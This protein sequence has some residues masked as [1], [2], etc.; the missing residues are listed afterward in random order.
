MEHQSR[1]NDLL[2]EIVEMIPNENQ[3]L[4]N[5]LSALQDSISEDQK[6]LDSLY[7]QLS[8][9]ESA[10]EKLTSP[11]NRTGVFLQLLEVGIALISVGDSEFIAS[12][13]PKI[14]SEEL[15]CGSR[16]KVNDTYSVVGVMPP[17]SG[18]QVMRVAEVLTNNRVRIGDSGPGNTSGRVVL[19]SA[20]LQAVNIKPGDEV[21][22]EPNMKVAVEHVKKSENREYFFEEIP[23]I[24][25]EKIGGQKEAIRLIK[26]TIEHPLLYPEIYESFE[27][28]PIKG[29]LLYGPP[30]CGKT[31]IGKAT[32]H[33][34]TKAYSE[35]IGK[36]IEE[37]FMY[38]SGPKILNMW[39]GETERMVRE[40]FETAREKAKEGKL[41]FIFFDEAESVLRTR[42]NNRWLNISNTVVPQFC[43]ELDGLVQLE[44][45]VLMLTSNRPDYIDPAILRPERIDRKVKINR[46]DEA[47]TREIFSIYLNSKIP[48]DPKAIAAEGGDIESLRSCMLDTITAYLWR[49]NKETEYLKINFKNGREETLYWRDLLSGALI[50]SIVDRAKDLAIMRAIEQPKQKHGIRLDDLK[51]ATEKEFL[52]NEIFPK[53]DAVDDWMKLLDFEDDYVV[54]L[55]S[56]RDSGSPRKDNII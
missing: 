56:V 38:I 12:I 25:W 31:L 19:L 23:E 1:T 52:E 51:R 22:I 8:E 13:D 49:T 27:K 53:N 2:K 6:S 55:R 41:V 43:A 48:L 32:A 5:Y 9:Y 40:I 7:Q 4:K 17:H 45:V 14:Q 21:R 37:Y 10:Y 24:E 3:R 30:G 47:A 36:N 42:S 54:S 28:K 50:K 16:V 33:N 29:I 20:E 39:L 34:I 18:G 44:N 11:S 26:D 46:P 35:R 15:V